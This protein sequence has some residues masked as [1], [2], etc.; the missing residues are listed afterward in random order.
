MAAGGGAVGGD[1]GGACEEGA[2]GGAVGGACETATGVGGGA[3]V[4]A[5]AAIGG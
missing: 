3:L 5:V 2:V 4:D 1:V